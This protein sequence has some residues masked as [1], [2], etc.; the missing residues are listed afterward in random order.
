MMTAHW[1]QYAIAEIGVKETPGPGDTPRILDY[2]STVAL[3]SSLLHDSTAHCSAFVNWVMKQAG[4]P[5]T[6]SAA[7][8]SWLE[9][10]DALYEP[11]Y[12]CVVILWRKKVDSPFGHVG[13]FTA[14]RGRSVVL[15][16]GNQ[17]DTVSIS[18]YLETRVL[19]YRWPHGVAKP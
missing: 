4:I 13:F 12:G 6:G 3:P 19:G 9:W 10:G 15:L 16:G 5:G 11:T 7:A 8:R 1:M 17:G 14:L 2:L 18:P